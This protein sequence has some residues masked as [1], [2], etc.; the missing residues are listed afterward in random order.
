LD[1]RHYYAEKAH[2]NG[3]QSESKYALNASSEQK[4]S[5]DEHGEDKFGHLHGWDWTSGE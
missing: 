3:G 1:G 4:Y 2:A 5:G